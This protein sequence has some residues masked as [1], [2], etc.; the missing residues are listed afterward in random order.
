M[1]ARGNGPS[2]PAQGTNFVRGSLNYGPIASL[3]TQLFGFISQKQSSYDQDFHVYALEWT[4]DWMRLYVDSRLKATMNLKITG[5]GGKDFFQRGNYPDTTTNGSA[6]AVVVENIWE[7]Q[8]GSPAAP[9]DQGES[10]PQNPLPI[11]PPR[12]TRAAIC[13]AETERPR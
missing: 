4:P 11:P 10:P 3:P 9:F 13:T 7:E 6:V 2:Y 5:H 12:A 1:E 8:G